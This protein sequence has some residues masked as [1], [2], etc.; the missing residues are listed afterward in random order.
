M[1]LTAN[2]LYTI[3]WFIDTSAFTHM[4]MKVHSPKGMMTLVKG[5]VISRYIK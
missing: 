5:A 3:R 2:N 4:N 1:K